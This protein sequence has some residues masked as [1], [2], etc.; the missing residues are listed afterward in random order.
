MPELASQS[1][2][3]AAQPRRRYTVTPR[4]LAANRRNLE[5]ANAVPKEIR[6]RPTPKRL[7][8][9]RRNLS[10]AQPARPPDGSVH[11][12]LG[13]GS[14]RQAFRRSRKKLTQFG[15]CLRQVRRILRPQN[16]RQADVARNVARIAWGW[17]DLLRDQCEEE[18]RLLSAF[19]QRA[20]P[21]GDTPG[22]SKHALE[23]FRVFTRRW[24]LIEKCEA[25][26]A[27]LRE[28]ASPFETSSQPFDTSSEAPSDVLDPLLAPGL[29]NP[30]QPDSQAE[31]D[32]AP[33]DLDPAGIEESPADKPLIPDSSAT[34]GE[35]AEELAEESEELEEPEEARQSENSETEGA[36]S[37]WP[38]FEEYQK[39]V[40]AALDVHPDLTL[41]A[42]EIARLSW[43]RHQVMEDWE[44]QASAA[45]QDLLTQ[46]PGPL[47]VGELTAKLEAALRGEAMRQAALQGTQLEVELK[48]ALTKYL[49]ECYGFQGVMNLFG[50]VPIP[51]S[52]DRGNRAATAP[53]SG[54]PQGN[55]AAAASP[56]PGIKINREKLLKL[57][58]EAERYHDARVAAGKT[59]PSP[60]SADN[61]TREEMQERLEYVK[62]RRAELTEQINAIAR[63][64]A[65]DLQ[66]QGSPPEA[67][68]SQPEISSS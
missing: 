68:P 60:R 37:G 51:S 23:R 11:S 39:H 64:R 10:K 57:L 44:T 49:Y 65:A 31:P 9:C 48:A 42:Q 6:Y 25:C 59:P 20:W 38:A 26:A 63:T 67:P 14:I 5:K 18:R 41:R 15:D 30:F 2:P 7:A 55:A 34:P 12:P 35:P 21:A 56:E 58:R 66:E 27:R 19:W 24:P 28:L 13:H 43:E 45:L 62:R 8:A 1:A 53:A 36:A 22:A 33:L 54:Q 4:V 47:S 29:G 40:M 46:T 32:D 16:L 17:L 61:M 52:P 50:P 3:P